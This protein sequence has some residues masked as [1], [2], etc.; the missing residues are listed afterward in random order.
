MFLYVPSESFFHRLHPVTRLLFLV[1]L[2]AAP[3]AAGRFPHAL[4]LLIVYTAMLTAASGR[5]NLVQFWK[6]LV[7]FWTFAFLIWIVVP[8]LR[9]VKWGFEDAAVLA[10]RIDCFVLAGLFFVTT[11]RTEEFTYALTR[12]GFPYKPA[13]TLSLGFRLVPLFYHSLQTIVSSQKSR[14]V[15]LESAGLLQRARSY[16]PIL[17]ILISYGIRN[18]D[19][20]AVSLEAKGFGYSD[21]RTALLRPRPGW[22]D[23]TLGA[24]VLLAALVLFLRARLAGAL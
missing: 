19:L 24:C 16:V 12:L 15:D 20:M 8:T 5:R 9:G 7:V 10:T 3:F 1:A 11:T 21:R 2:I 23:A 6:L 13:F 17:T 14:G 18:A 22:R 4:G